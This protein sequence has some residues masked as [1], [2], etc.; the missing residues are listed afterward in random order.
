MKRILTAL[1]LVPL[2]LLLIFKGSF[3]LVVIAT[4]IVAELA[5]WEYLALADILGAKTPRILVLAAI[6]F[7]FAATFRNMDLMMP[8]LGLAA[9]VLFVVCAF[10]SP[11]ERVLPDTAYSVF[12]L[13]YIGF[14]LSTIPLLWADADGPS[15][16][17][18]LFC[19]VWCG[20]VAAL[21]IGRAYGRRKLAPRMSPQKTWEGSAASMAAGLAITALLFFL[22]HWL[23]ERSLLSIAY[24]GGLG[25]W[26]FLA[27]LL[28][29]AA[30]LG[31]LV[32]SAIKRGSGA[33]DSGRL[34][35]GHGGILDRIDALLLAAPLLWYAQLTQQY[36]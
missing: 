28:N 31:D 26:L 19:V 1:V 33:K 36:F 23:Q 4:A 16:L 35:P 27:V 13:I 18:L 3:F 21:Y 14:S 7:L 8:S 6:A 5:A 9:L 2:V 12:A 22:A 11:L 24:P 25:H 17:L 34:L 15:L 10:R 32:E 20:D 30:Q 29:V